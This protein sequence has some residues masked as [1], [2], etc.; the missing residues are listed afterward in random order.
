MKNATVTRSVTS[1]DTAHVSIVMRAYHNDLPFASIAY[2]S[3]GSGNN[4]LNATCHMV[5]ED[6]ISNAA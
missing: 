3:C 4:F 2:F 6:Y 5:D 1:R